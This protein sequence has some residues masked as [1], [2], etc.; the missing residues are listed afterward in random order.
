MRGGLAA[1]L[2]LLGGALARGGAGDVQTRT[3]HPWYP[4]ELA[5][6]TFPRLFA[7]QAEAY[8]RAT[9]RDVQ[10]DEDKAI[11][12]W[13]WRN[14][15]YYHSTEGGRDL[16]G[17]GPGQGL[18]NVNREY[19]NGLF[20]DGFSLCF[21]THAQ[22]QGEM[23]ALLGRGRSRCCGVPG[24]TSFEVYLTGGAYGAGRWALLDHDISTIY[25]TPDGARLMSL[26][27]VSAGL[28]KLLGR[29]AEQN[30][31]W[32]PG[33]LHPGDPQAYRSF[34]TAMYGYGYAGAPPLVHLRAG[35]SVRRYLA[36]GLED[37]K[38]F[39]FWGINYAAGG[40]PG[41]H[42]DRTWVNQPEKMYRAARDAGSRFGQWYG[43][44]VY[45]Y[46]P[47][48]ARGAYREAVVDESAG[49]VTLEF[50]TP[51]IIGCTPVDLAPE[52]QLRAVYA[53]GAK[54]GLVIEG[55]IS[56][57]VSL[58]VDHGRSW[59]RAEQAGDRLDLTDLVKGRRQYWL[60]LHAGAKSLA[61]CDLTIRT[62]CQASLSIVPRLTAG[63][64]RITYSA[65]GTASLA[66]G[67]DMGL[68]VAHVVEGAIGGS[69]PVTLKL[70]APRGEKGVHVYAAQRQAS[71]NPPRDVKYNIDCSA[72]GGRTWL[73]LVDE[74][75]L[76]RHEPEP[77]DCWSQSHVWGDAAVPPT[78]GP[79][80]VRFDSAGRT[81]QRCEAHLIYEVENTSPVKVTYAWKEDGQVKTAAHTYA[82]AV[83]DD[84]SWTIDA[85]AAPETLWV[86][87]A[88]EA[89]Q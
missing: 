12:A 18:D 79:V 14:T 69:R 47:D 44:A 21:A 68:A 9:G 16:W 75:P 22:W 37:G 85:G 35:E 39:V 32:L 8:R 61:Q 28:D 33:G 80:L 20:A 4:G 78:S 6:S 66:A 64:N 81:L 54:N 15:H 72:D 13:Y 65:G 23:Q 88:A 34:D 5:C 89:P 31:G 73:P 55:R 46:R 19:W 11:A 2:V 41:P 59:S 57:P 42:R 82:A 36:P 17:T 25:F 84:A 87:Y 26:T 53:P 7:T 48:F 52:K 43:N 63:K 40:I 29:T 71:G 56:C 10:S 86:E 3:D 77:G 60:R 67:P 74:Q 38:T 50:S 49:H 83:V 76:I 30:R 24:H 51:Y 62:V 70:A 1:I 27:E 58:S 45:T